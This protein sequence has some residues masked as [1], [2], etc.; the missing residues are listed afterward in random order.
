MAINDLLMEATKQL[1]NPKQ[2]SAL[3]NG[4][5]VLLKESKHSRAKKYV[6]EVDKI[7]E[8]INGLALN[9]YLTKFQLVTMITSLANKIHKDNI[10]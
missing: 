1:N 3:L 7:R 8:L 10:E 6:E 2:M 9:K 4:V 5:N